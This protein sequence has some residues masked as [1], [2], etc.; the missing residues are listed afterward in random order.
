MNQYSDSVKKMFGQIAGTYDFL[1]HFLSL[2]FDIYWR[3]KMVSETL[4]VLRSGVSIKSARR[5]ILDAAA[6]T[7]DVLIEI[8]K[9]AKTA[10]PGDKTHAPDVFIC[11]DFSL[12]MLLKAREKIK[13]AFKSSIADNVSFVICDAQNPCFKDSSVDA[14]TVAFGLRNFPDAGSFFAAASRILKQDGVLS[15]LEFRNILKYRV[16]KLFA[17]YYEFF[18]TKLGKLFSGHVFAYK[19]LVESIMAFPEDKEIIARIEKNNFAV[20]RYNTLLPYI[21]SLYVA[22][23][24]KDGR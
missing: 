13:T 12:P 22:I 19:Y 2:G 1:N 21:V 24:N 17:G 6:G 10:Y 9:T 3:K 8:I 11:S 20:R 18:V 23:I 14:I 7:G 4:G 5:V 15:I 16:A